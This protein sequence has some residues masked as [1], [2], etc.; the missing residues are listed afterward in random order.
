MI[1][2]NTTDLPVPAIDESKLRCE[3]HQGR[4]RTG[5]PREEEASSFAGKTDQFGLV[6]IQEHRGEASFRGREGAHAGDL[7]LF[8]RAL[9]VGGLG[10]RGALENGVILGGRDGGE[11]RG[12][13]CETTVLDVSSALLKTL[14][15]GF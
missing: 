4:R 13:L 2:L 8:G 11:G 9:H 10:R 3:Q 14:L 15:Y 1:S 6:H 7:D 12:N 5:T